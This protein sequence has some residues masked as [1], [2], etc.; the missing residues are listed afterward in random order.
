MILACGL[1]VLSSCQS[2]TEDKKVSEDQAISTPKPPGR[3]DSSQ[4][5]KE[6]V[7]VDYIAAAKTIRQNPKNGV[8]FSKLDYD[9]LI[10][11]DFAGSANTYPSV[12]DQ[13]GNFVPVVMG[14]QYLSQEQADKILSA[15]T[16]NSTY[17]EVTAAC[18]EPHFALV[19]YK[20]NKKV[21][22]I[23][24]CLDCNYLIAEIEIPA[25]T[26]GFTESGRK[27]IIDLCKELN[28]RYGSLEKI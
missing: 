16:N 4:I 5:I 14:Q 21:T 10:A 12:I 17:G 7:L 6:N 20:D 23:N 22:Q 9:K 25:E 27:A 3:L 15:L 24:V 13:K 26:H 28:F 2:N 11:Y 1:T 18:F 19:L 8:P